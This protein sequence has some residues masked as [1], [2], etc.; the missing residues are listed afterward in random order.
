VSPE[1]IDDLEAAL[2]QYW[3]SAGNLG[4]ATAEVN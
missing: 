3:L 4:E 2:E 1:M